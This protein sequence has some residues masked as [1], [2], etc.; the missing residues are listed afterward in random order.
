VS[1]KRIAAKTMQSTLKT[2]GGQVMMTVTT[3]VS[4]DGKT[5]TLTFKGTDGQGHDIN[6]IVVYDKE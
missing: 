1:V 3:T 2:K 5:R 6:N 4:A